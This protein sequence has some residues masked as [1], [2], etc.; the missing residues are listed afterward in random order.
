M[1]VETVRSGQYGGWDFMSTGGHF[2]LRPWHKSHHPQREISIAA[3]LAVFPICT[4]HG[5]GV[6]V[7]VNCFLLCAQRNWKTVSTSFHVQTFSRITN[8]HLIVHRRCV[9]WIGRDF[10]CP[11]VRQRTSILNSNIATVVCV[12]GIRSWEWFWHTHTHTHTHTF[13]YTYKPMHAYSIFIHRLN[14]NTNRHTHSN[15]RM[16]NKYIDQLKR[17]RTRTWH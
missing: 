15:T 9:S 14:S 2:R 7:D 5:Q 4:L 17:K 1:D 6:S 12:R 8:L 11:A 16:H 3:L 10:C 13:T